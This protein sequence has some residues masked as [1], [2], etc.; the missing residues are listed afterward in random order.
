MA[1][2]L[3]KTAEPVGAKKPGRVRRSVGAIAELRRGMSLPLASLG[4]LKR[5]RRLFAYAALPLLINTLVYIG[6][7]AGGAFLIHAW[8]P[9]IPAWEFWGPV[10]GWISG[11]INWMLPTLKWGFMI[12]IFL[13]SYFSF[14]AVGMILASPFNDLLSEKV[15]GSLCEARSIATPTPLQGAY[16]TLFSLGDT[17]W[18]V[19]RQL[20]CMILVL[21]LLFIPI[22]GW[23]PL[24]LVTAHYT[25]LGFFEVATARNLLRNSHKRPAV[26]AWRWRI[27]GLGIAMEIMFLIPFGGLFVLPLG[28]IAGT[29]IYCDHDWEQT[30][31]EID[32]PRPTRY[33]APRLKGAAQLPEERPAVKISDVVQDAP[34]E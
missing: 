6:A 34:V 19:T 14:R 11:F 13:A 7:I 3:P 27:L 21:P 1:E 9:S 30:L 20:L 10:G 29:L 32:K 22:V 23:L 33:E 5:H 12:V 4:V 17:I 25:G 31:T 26:K 24:F 16:V 28:V 18:N 2:R 8:Q 15:E